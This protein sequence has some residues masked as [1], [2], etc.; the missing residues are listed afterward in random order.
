MRTITSATPIL[1]EWDVNPLK[2][3]RAQVTLEVTSYIKDGKDKDPIQI[4]V[5]QDTWEV[6]AHALDWIKY[7]IEQIAPIQAFV[8]GLGGTIA[9]VLAWF[10]IKGFGGK[11]PD[12]ET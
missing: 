9:A 11:R 3:G 2:P 10:G 1:W 4:R 7:Q 6:D 5:L 12:L 8:V